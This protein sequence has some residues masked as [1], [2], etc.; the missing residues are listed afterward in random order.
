MKSKYFAIFLGAVIFLLHASANTTNAPHITS[1]KIQSSV[2]GQSAKIIKYYVDVAPPGSNYETGSLHIIY[3]DKT[4]VIQKISSRKT[5]KNNEVIKNQ[6]GITKVA[7]T[8]DKRTIGWAETFDD[9]NNSS[10]IPM[11]LAIYRSGNSVLRLY[12]GQMLWHWNFLDSG[13]NLAAVWGPTHGPEVGDYQ[14][15]DVNSGRM[16]SEVFGDSEVQALKANAP[17]WAKQ[18]ET[19]MH[20]L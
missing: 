5:G 1:T 12:Q 15:Y 9:G 4:E 17:S 2:P 13:K 6:E 11:I 14:L 7:I 16:I 20:A 18:T 3:S 10:A 19:K 8:K